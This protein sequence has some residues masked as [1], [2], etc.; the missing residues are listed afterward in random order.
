MKRNASPFCSLSTVIT[1]LLPAGLL[2]QI[3]MLAAALN[4][5]VQGSWPGYKRGSVVDVAVAGQ[6]AYLATE[7]AGLRVLDLSDPT[8]PVRIGSYFNRTLSSR[9]ARAMALAGDYA[10]LAYA[11]GSLEV[12]DVSNPSD[13]RRVGTG[14]HGNLWAWPTRL[15]VVPPH[16]LVALGGQGLAIMDVADPANP[17]LITRYTGN[18][19][20]E[21]VAVSG[22]YAYLAAGSEGLEV[23]DWSDPAAPQAVGHYPGEYVRAVAVAGSTAWIMTG[24]EGLE[25][26]DVS[27]PTQPRRIGQHSTG[28]M[29]ERIV[30]EGTRT[31]VALHNSWQMF[32]LSDPTNPGPIASYETRTEITGAVLTGSSA[33]LVLGELQVLDVSDPAEAQLVGRYSESGYAANIAV[34][35]AHAYLADGPAGFRVLDVSDASNPSLLGGHAVSS[36]AFDVVVSGNLAFVADQLGGLEIFDLSDPIDPRKVSQVPV[37]KWARNVAV[38]GD[39][40]YLTESDLAFPAAPRGYRGELRVI[41]I[42]DPADPREVGVHDLDGSAQSLVLRGSHALVAV[43]WDD[44][45]RIQDDPPVSQVIPRGELQ[46]IDVSDPANPRLVVIHPTDAWP[47]DLAVMENLVCLLTRLPSS[48]EDRSRLLV[49]DLSDPANPR[50]LGAYERSGWATTVTTG[51]GYAFVGWERDRTEGSL[52]II[53]LADPAQP[54]R[55]GGSSA[56]LTVEDLKLMGNQLFA[57]AAGE[58]LVVLELPPILR[59]MSHLGGQLHLSWEGFGPVRLEQAARLTDPDWQDLG[60]PQT[61][62]EYTLPASPDPSFFRL[63]RP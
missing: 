47:V 52:D 21:D 28:G 19:V 41:D 34:A 39:Y 40:A 61:A 58:G 5:I 29:A 63:V 32:D 8:N 36:S 51:G 17:Q 43:G 20:I 46:V 50:E 59:S 30:V 1:Y 22:R 60:A 16:A 49:I 62:N 55:V 18:F 10:Y 45:V 37:T 14:V 56:I 7:N 33:L 23:V 53:D 54:R 42:S 38:S 57:A 4:P 24:T 44:R 12:V 11:A 6:Y 2:L 13:P 26:I 27:D 48:Q 15:V 35:G 31:L 9:S 25:A 3:P